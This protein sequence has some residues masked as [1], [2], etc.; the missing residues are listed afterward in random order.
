MDCSV[1]CSRSTLPS[2][3]AFHYDAS[4]GI[5]QLG[6]KVP[7]VEASSGKALE[8]HINDA[9]PWYLIARINVMKLFSFPLIKAKSEPQ[10]LSFESFYR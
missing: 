1:R 2:C 4:S 8:I 7:L 6:S 10:C 5:C 3:S 9:D